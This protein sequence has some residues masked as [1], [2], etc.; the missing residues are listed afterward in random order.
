M[1]FRGRVYTVGLLA[2]MA[3]AALCALLPYGA[4]VAA[5]LAV[6]VAAVAVRDRLQTGEPLLRN[7]PVLGRLHGLLH[8]AGKLLGLQ[9]PQA[10]YSWALVD[11]VRARARGGSEYAAFGAQLDAPRV[12]ILHAMAPAP[13]EEVPERLVIGEGC[14]QPYSASYLNL[15]A[16]AFGAISDAAIEALCR[17]AKDGAF[18]CNTGEAGVPEV[19]LRAGADLVW[20]LGTGYFG[21]RDRAGRFDEGAFRE[22][23]ALPAIKMIEL[24]LSQGAKPA[25]GGILPAEKATPHVAEACQIPV[26]QACVVPPVHSAFSTPLELMALVARLREAAGGKPVGLKLCVGQVRDLFALVKAMLATGVTPD[27]LAVDG[28]EG[29]TGAAPVEFQSFVGLRLHQ[30]LPLVHDALVGAGLRARVRVIA[31]GKITT[32]ADMV[33][34]LVHGADLCAAARPFMIAMGC[35]Q[36]LICA[37]NECPVG[38]ATQDPRL[39]RGLVPRAQAANVT[40]YHRQTV[41]A[42]RELVAAT[43]CRSPAELSAAHLAERRAS[44]SSS[45]LLRPGQLLDDAPPAE[46]AEAWRAASAARF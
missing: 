37:S 7:Y 36:A 46:Y 17:G 42:F 24:K 20:Q 23:A 22:R 4:L 14:A 29:G 34:A 30:A 25:K 10:P 2:V 35:I 15:S 12:S 13:V 38:L 43:G 40:R 1:T 18:F 8:Q 26:G 3:A 21:C 45:A 9:Q 31:S 11:L 44:A 27:F 33:A 32:G 5:A 28:A 39:T 6:L 19:F 16:M 41:H